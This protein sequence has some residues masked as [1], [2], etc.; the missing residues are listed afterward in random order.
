VIVVPQR[1]WPDDWGGS[2][3]EAVRLDGGVIQAPAL[4]ERGVQHSVAQINVSV[5]TPGARRFWHIHPNQS[6]MWTIAY[7][8]LNAGLIDC[9]EGCRTFGVQAKVILTPDRAL[10]IPAGVAHGFANESAGV[11]VLQY[12]VNRQFTM[13]EDTEEWRLD[14]NDVPYDFVLGEVI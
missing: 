12:L 2:F 13:S 10:Y 11:V 3:K 4:R 1:V 6:E 8:Q 14:P 5:I 7:G 9:R